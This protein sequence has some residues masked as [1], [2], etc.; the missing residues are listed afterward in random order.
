MIFYKTNTSL[1]NELKIYSTHLRK[2][3]KFI[4]ITPG[5][6]KMY[7]CGPTV[8]GYLHIGNFRGPV[9]FNLVQNFLRHIGY[10]V[11]FALNFTDVDDKIIARAKEMGKSAGEVSEYYIQAYKDDY[12]TLE[13]GKHTYNPKV[14][15]SMNDIIQMISDLIAKKHAYES[16]GDVWFSVDSFKDYGKLSGRQIEELLSGVRVEHEASKR[17]PADFA[18]WKS[19]KP[20]EP[21]WSSPWGQGRPGWHI[22]CSAMIRSLFGDK[23]DIHGGGLDLLFPHHENEIAQSEGCSHQTFVNYWMHVNMLN[24]GGQKMSKSLGNLVSLRDFLKDHHPEVYK[25]M[26][27][28]VHYRSLSEFSPEAVDRAIGSLAKIYSGLALAES[29]LV[30]HGVSVAEYLP[31]DATIDEKYK[32]ELQTQTAKV[33]KALC[34]D[35]A[36]PQVVAVIYDVLRQFNQQFKRGMKLN[37]LQL[38]KVSLF[39]A[40]ILET[41]SLLSLF[42]QPAQSFLMALDEKLLESKKV[43]KTEVES[44][45][46]ERAQFRSEKNFAKSDELRDQLLA[47]GVSVMDTPQ[48]SFW[49]VTK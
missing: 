5:Q 16:N 21:S 29:L 32:A 1:Q 31:A 48:G 11:E 38:S 34:D 30:S 18:L 4:P 15:D 3:E 49:E 39:R 14:T 25:W 6:V 10:D 44:L 22:E 12:A 23:I 40:F 17:N 36:T 41:G 13:L 2:E 33:E 24:F 45:V 26:I 47:L 20:D 28:S 46:A 35:F 9:F 43:S 37:L 42:Q 27:L 8:Y 7:V 19:A